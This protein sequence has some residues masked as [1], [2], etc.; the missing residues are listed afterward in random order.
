MDTESRRFIIF[1][2]VFSLTINTITS[3]TLNRVLCL[4][5]SNSTTPQSY[6]ST[7]S[8][9]LS[10]LPSNS[11][12]FSTESSADGTIHSLWLCR[13]DVLQ[14]V[15]TACIAQAVQTVLRSCPNHRSAIVWYDE[16]ML[17]YSNVT[18]FGEAQ[19]APALVMGNTMNTSS[20][21]EPNNGALALVYALIDRVPYTR[22]MYGTNES[23]GR[24]ENRYA[25]AQCTRDLNGSDCGRCLGRLNE[26]STQC[27][28]GRIGWRVLA[29]SCSLRYEQSRFY[30]LPEPSPESPQSSPGGGN[31]GTEEGSN[32]TGKIVGITVSAIVLV[33]L[34]I[35]GT[36]YCTCFRNKR[37]R[38]DE[39]G[40]S[41]EILLPNFNGSTQNG[42]VRIEGHE[43]DREVHVYSLAAIQAA[44]NN[45]S[46]ENKLGQGGFGPVYKGKLPDGQ[47]IAVK[48]LSL[49]SKQGLEE[50]RNEVMVIVKLQHRNLVRLLGYCLEKGEKLLVYEYLANTSLDAF[51]FDKVKCEE[52]DWERRANI[53]EGTARGLMYLHED[54]RLKII[55]RD[56][57][58]SNVLLDDQMNPKISDFGTARIF[59]GNQIEANTERVVGTYGYMAPE[60]ALEGM[61]S[62][63]SDVYS[64][65]IL[66]LEIISG[67][68]N[69]GSFDPNQASSLLLHAWELWSE[70]RGEELIDSK[71]V[72]SCPVVDALRW[73]HIALLCTQD[74]PS[75]RPTMSTVVRML[76]S[77]SDDL[78]MQLKR[79]FTAGGGGFIHASDLSSTSGT[80]TGTGTG[81]LTSDQSNASGV[82]R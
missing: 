30:R 40:H 29:P 15:C 39:P 21:S 48:R 61:I 26:F 58:A 72:D 13:G 16:C 33:L 4:D 2:I 11:T 47:E 9:L 22:M 38:H 79:P 25:M 23:E 51:L 6:T 32:S 54:S 45:F 65:G 46:N 17:R 73:I 24:G 20:P 77:K 42:A 37:R 50:F 1:F 14:D 49:T 53:V 78:P 27:C 56:M 59:G 75:E 7:L 64:F 41:E 34:T 70:D 18:F 60:Y 31:N 5:R 66:M 57:K 12:T 68:K 55:H 81:F 36:W 44:T 8:T 43:D 10:S 67:K 71:I 28:Q 82:S 80:G 3:Q 52:L 62:T 69:R 35:A 74:D 63:K 19:T 76:G